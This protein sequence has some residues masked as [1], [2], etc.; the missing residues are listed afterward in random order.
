[1]ISRTS[2]T[3]DTWK[4]YKVFL[5]NRLARVYPLHIFTFSL[6]LITDILIMII[7]DYYELWYDDGRNPSLLI[8]TNITLTHAWGFYEGMSFNYP[9]WSISTE[10]LAY[11]VFPVLSALLSKKHSY[12]YFV[13]CLVLL[14]CLYLVS[15]Q[16][17]GLLSVDFKYGFCVYRCIILFSVGIILFEISGKLSKRIADYT[18]SDTSLLLSIVFTVILMDYGMSADVS[19][20]PLFMWIVISAR[21]N[22]GVFYKILSLKPLH[23]LG[24]I[25]YSIYMNHAFIQTTWAMIF[26]KHFSKIFTKT[27]GITMFFL[28]MMLV[29]VCSWF[30]YI[31][32]EKPARRIIKKLI[33]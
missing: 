11:L 8:L 26:P 24:Q 15:F 32:I 33:V 22:K 9:S 7:L 27:Q 12:F 17:Q 13:S 14:A 3:E 21:F 10:F 31:F 23:F 20:I 4:K 2:E 28:F 1:M 25:S 19:V 29:L 6:F 5:R 16:K 30:T 18:G